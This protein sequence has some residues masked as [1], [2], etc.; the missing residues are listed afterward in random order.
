MGELKRRSTVQDDLLAGERRPG[1]G[2]RRPRRRRVNPWIFVRSAGV[3]LAFAAFVLFGLPLLVRADRLRPQL[4]R[5]LSEMTGRHVE[6]H[7]LHYSLLHRALVGTDFLI[8]EDPGFG[9][10]PFLQA[11]SVEFDVPFWSAVFGRDPK[12]ARIAL[13]SPTIVLKEDAQGRWNYSSLVNAAGRTHADFAPP[14]LEVSGGRVGVETENAGILQL[15]KLELSIPKPQ[16]Q[17]A[18]AF[19]L[20]GTVMSHGKLKVKGEAGP[21]GW[22]QGKPV[23]PISALIDL[24]GFDLSEWTMGGTVTGLGGLLS[25]DG[26]LE[27]NGRTV[28]FNGQATSSRLKLSRAG[29]GA[30]DPL[31]AVFTLRHDLDTHSGV[32]SRCDIGV[33]KG[34]ASLQGK[35]DTSGTSVQLDFNL[36][37]RGAPVTQLAQFLPALGIDLPPGAGLEGGDVVSNLH[38]QG[39]IGH[40]SITGPLS[41]DDT[42]LNHFYLSQ[43]METVSGLDAQE[44]DD[45]AEILSWKCTLESTGN[46]IGVRDLVTDIAGLG[47]LSGS[48]TI[49]PD[50]RLR[51]TMS[52]IRGL[53]GPKGTAIP[54]TVTGTSHDPV[55]QPLDRKPE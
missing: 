47:E 9:S 20:S 19:T 41:V 18:S 29:R 6:L 34:M 21:I 24:R 25:I 35:Y 42:R 4:E 48:G 2:G 3:V 37:L 49:T 55:F 43:R 16:S 28:D 52:G 53:T 22:D 38:L 23:L 14:A 40:P 36:S 7:A 51:F 5:S 33:A 10:V 11:R 39:P 8:A 1:R 50:G 31:E 30:S 46:G 17:A 44:L 27:S 12:V 15:Q 13:D 32:L 54:F 26:S 45:S